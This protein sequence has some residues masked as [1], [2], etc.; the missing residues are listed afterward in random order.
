[1][2]I[3]LWIVLLGTLISTL[4][5]ATQTIHHELTVRLDPKAGTLT[6]TDAI[7][8]PENQR[9]SIRYFLL[10]ENLEIQ[11]V[12]SGVVIREENRTPRAA[13]FGL[14]ENRFRLP[15]TPG[16]RLYRIEFTEAPEAPI[17][18]TITYRGTIRHPLQQM[19]EEYERA[20]SETPGIISEEGVYLAGSS[21]WIPWFNATLIT[22][23]LTTE[24]PRGWDAVSQ[25]K[26]TLHEQQNDRQVTRW[27][28]PHPMEEVYLIAAPFHEYH[29]QVG[30]VT[31][32]AFLRTPDESLANKYLET[33][34]QYLEM[35]RQLIGPYPYSKFALVENFW[36]T[37]YG[38]PSFTLLGPRI[39]RFP[40]ILHSSYPH[41]L[42]HN[43]WGN[44]VFVDYDEG[45]WCEGL[46]AYMADH[47]IK[48]QRGQGEDY[49]R[50]TLQKF[51]DYVHPAND[52]PL[53]KFRN[54][55][56]AASEAIGYG[57]T[58][59][60]FHMLRRQVGDETFIRAFQRFYRE[61]KFRR[62]NFEDIRRAFE[63]VTGQSFADF[64][65]QWTRRTGAPQLAIS[66]IRLQQNHPKFELEL[67][68]K[69]TQEEAPF[70]LEVP[71]AVTLEGESRVTWKTVRMTQREQTFRLAFDRRP[72]RVDVD[73]QFDVFRRLDRNEI[74]P[75]LSKAFGASRV[76][77]VLPSDVPTPLKSA[78]EKLAETW[79][80]EKTD[81]IS[82]TSDADLQQLPADRAVWIF[83]WKNQFLSLFQKGLADY[84]VAIQADGVRF[85]NTRVPSENHSVVIATRHPGNPASVV[86]WL[87]TRNPNAWNGLARKLPHYGKYSY[88]AFEGDEPT[89]VVK[90]QWPVVNSPLTRSVPGT[91]GAEQIVPVFPKRSALAQLK[92]LFSARR[93]AQHIAYLSSPELEGRGV[94]TRGIDRA[95]QYIAEQFQAAGL[96]PGGD[97]NTYFQSWEDV[98][99]RDN[100]KVELKNVIGILPGSHPDWKDQSV[101]ISAHYDHLGYG[102]PDVY[103]GNEGKLHPGADDNASG[104]AVLLEL[105]KVLGKSEKPKRTIIFIA[106][107]A[108]ESGLRGS[109]YYVRHSGDYPV[110]KLMGVINLDTVGRLKNN[111]LLVLN[112]NTA[113]EWRFIFMG[114][115][116]VTGVE[117]KVIDQRLDASDQVP[118][119]EAGVPAVQLFSGAH[120]DYHRP[121]DTADK[122]D[123]DGLVKVATFVR[124]A[125]LYLAEREEPLTV[126]IAGAESSHR[127]APPRGTRRVSTGTVPDFA[128][129]GEGV[130]IGS[131]VPDS[132]AAQAGLQAGDII[133]RVEDQPIKSLRDYSDVLKKYNPGDTIQLTVLRDH[134]EVEVRLTLKAR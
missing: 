114:A 105:A 117:S 37:G 34:G 119:I 75:A 130:K 26:R 103:Q 57:K 86:V 85:G 33:T 73:P 113:R 22:F 16:V 52:F 44:G 83:G 19:A 59:M 82:V 28:C 23:N 55:Y 89:N 118:F 91:E 45:N 25:G 38:M 61:N 67:T 95:A 94:D 104:V 66:N 58:L 115:S 126:T 123:L 125:L 62:A 53:V 99:G 50:S 47:Q 49:R 40:F 122:I 121:G 42:L 10:H 30:A 20:F 4:V 43:W 7:S 27:E 112:A 65:N 6:V 133:I 92:P 14:P 31:V 1:M 24:L 51:T 88:L 29:K 72:L 74:P 5:P 15:E 60:M 46:T 39:I 69:Q 21:Y 8:I 107:T 131:I 68:L 84:D 2:N 9:S 17:R 110:S 87:A 71:I 3:R 120:L 13:D 64:F 132:P 106:F 48:E 77:I 134:Q 18:F 102:W 96:L 56:S 90:G 108:E 93:M 98:A 70:V 129:S 76:L 116:Y 78:Y 79:A 35:Y 100:R 97:N 41:E 54:R 63:A 11:S 111:P 32:F 12:S 124:E 128:Y 80:G 109:R 81:K 127:P 101:I 36:E